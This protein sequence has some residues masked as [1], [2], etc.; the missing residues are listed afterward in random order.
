MNEHVDELL[1]FYVNATLQEEQREAVEAHLKGCARC[2]MAFREWEDLAGWIQFAAPLQGQAGVA[3]GL[4]ALSP[5]VRANLRGKPSFPE[6]VLSTA[7]LIAAQRIFLK[8]S[9]MI[10]TLSAVLLASVLAGLFLPAKYNLTSPIPFILLVPLLAVLGI[11]FFETQEGDL[12]HEIVAATPTHPGVL[13]FAR[14]T[15]S[16]GV[17]A[18][19]ALVGSLLI[20]AFGGVSLGWLVVTWLGPMLWLPALATLLALLLNPWTAA[21]ISVTLWGGIALLLVTEGYGQSILGFSLAPLLYPSW[22]SFGLQV[23]MA[24][25]LWLICWLWLFWGA[26]PAL[27]LERNGAGFTS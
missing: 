20:A 9:W 25:I 24:G 21:G 5:V 1:P 4:P 19:L 12:S 16:L 18:G 10:L 26:P 14:L 23:L 17:I 11:S 6:A 27:R 2:R 3:S 13:T 8:E 15:L 7:S 22:W